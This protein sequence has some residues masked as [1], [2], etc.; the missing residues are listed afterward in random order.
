MQRQ[1]FLEVS[2]NACT[3]TP[4][5]HSE[6]RVLEPKHF[7]VL[8]GEQYANGDARALAVEVEF[9]TCVQCANRARACMGARTSDSVASLRYAFD[10]TSFGPTSDSKS[11]LDRLRAREAR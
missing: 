11:S 2:T 4:A 5:A 6:L 10:G 3:D 7:N 1:D 9:E 8:G